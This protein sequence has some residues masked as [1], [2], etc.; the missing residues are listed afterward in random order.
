MTEGYKLKIGD[1]ACI[2]TRHLTDGKL[3][4]SG[5]YVA[6][7]YVLWSLGVVCGI[8]AKTGEARFT[9]AYS[10]GREVYETSDLVAVRA[11]KTDAIQILAR[12]VAR[13]SRGKAWASEA[14]LLDDFIAAYDNL[15]FADR[16]P[17]GYSAL[18]E[19]AA[20]PR[21]I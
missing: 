13:S 2:A 19:G 12:E 9:R 7:S 6:A 17:K 20:R 3:P 15:K 14:L 18:A 4:L 11:L 16:A 8:D 5:R 21:T 10:K 1:Y